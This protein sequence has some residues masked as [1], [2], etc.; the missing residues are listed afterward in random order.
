MNLAR[1]HSKRYEPPIYLSI[2]PNAEET[3]DYCISINKDREAECTAV[4][5]GEFVFRLRR[6]GTSRWILRSN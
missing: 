4:D 6:R 3:E 1:N 5:A 2:F